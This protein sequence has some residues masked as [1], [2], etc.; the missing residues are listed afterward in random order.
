MGK[1]LA[2]AFPKCERFAEA[3]EALGYP[4]SELC[5]AGP[6]GRLVQTEYTQPAIL[7]VSAAV[8][9]LC[10][11]GPACAQG[12]W[13]GAAS[14]VRG[15]CGGRCLDSPARCASCARGRLM[16]EPC[17]GTGGMAAI[18]GLEREVVVELCRQVRDPR[19]RGTG[20][21]E[22]PG[23]TVVAGVNEALDEVLRRAGRR[24]PAGRCAWPS[25]V[26]SIRLFCVSRSGTRSAA[27]DGGVA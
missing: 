4:I 7:T 3:D 24:E 22:R 27:G 26:R 11:A 12:S 21:A 9:G 13:P 10:A 19:R 2:T 6:A 18:L 23:Q 16:E 25:A 17:P 8:C 1:E 5:F 14:A 15:T 20:Y